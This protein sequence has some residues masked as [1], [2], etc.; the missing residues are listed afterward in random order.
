[1][2]NIEGDT[3]QAIAGPGSIPVQRSARLQQDHA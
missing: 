3:V 2:L 1:M